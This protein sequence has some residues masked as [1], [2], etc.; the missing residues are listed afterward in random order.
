[1]EN[2][3]HSYVYHKENGKVEAGKWEQWTERNVKAGI[4][5]RGGSP[6]ACKQKTD[7]HSLR[8]ESVDQFSA[9][10]PLED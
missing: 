10:M 9:V 2:G 7:P 4:T 5:N 8:L 1:M 3:D 6:K